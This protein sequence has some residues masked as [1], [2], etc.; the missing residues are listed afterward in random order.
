MKKVYSKFFGGEL[1]ALDVEQLKI[2]AQAG[3]KTPKPEDVIADAGAAVVL[4][5]DGKRAYVVFNGSTG[6][7]SVRVKSDTL[8][9]AAVG[10]FVG[11]VVAAAIICKQLEAADP[12]RP[13]P[14]PREVQPGQ[15]TA[16]PL[17]DLLFKL[18]RTMA[19]AVRE[20][21][22]AAPDAQG[23]TPAAESPEVTE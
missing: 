11:E 23:T 10:A 4:P 9:P 12:D 8:N 15:Q 2:F 6:A 5:P 18:G 7:F 13:K 3:Y 1:Y 21:A 20:A 19:Q 16:A 17:N 22:Q 14:A